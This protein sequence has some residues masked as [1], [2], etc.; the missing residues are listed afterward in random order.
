[1]GCHLGF[2]TRIAWIAF[3]VGVL[4][5]VAMNFASARAIKVVIRAS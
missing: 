1:M 5:F 2:I 4:L 3:A